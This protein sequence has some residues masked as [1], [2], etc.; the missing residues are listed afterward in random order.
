MSSRRLTDPDVESLLS[1][2]TPEST[3]LAD[4]AAFLDE[5]HPYPTPAAAPVDTSSL[6]T[7]AA[8]VARS[9]R[10]KDSKPGLKNPRGRNLTRRLAVASL[11]VV[12]LLGMS[13]IAVGAN[14]AAPGH[15]L[16]SFDLFL[17]NFGIGNGEE[18]ERMKEAD[19]LLTTGDPDTA[20]VL[21][22]EYLEQLDTEGKSKA[23]EKV[24]RHI[25][26]AA[27]KSNPN[28]A[29]AQEKVAL[30][31]AFIEN[32]KGAGKGVDGKEFGQGVADIARGESKEPGPPES[33]GPK[34]GKGNA[35]DHAGPKDK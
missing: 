29:A 1:G 23:V 12:L 33:A 8:Q 16:Y 7:E 4:L 2:R 21:L 19:V 35:P 9:N 10:F 5:M 17:E 24:M 34:E 25:E 15:P 32:N 3:E 11:A 27:T 26:L 30:L 18:T 14:D 6:V 28:A 13:G 22:A 20:F 31:K